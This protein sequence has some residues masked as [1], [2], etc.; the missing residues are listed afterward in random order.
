MGRRIAIA[1]VALIASCQHDHATAP[2]PVPAPAPVAKSDPWATKPIP[3]DPLPHPLLWSIEKDGHTTFAL[4]TIHMG[5]DPESR[6]PDS[7]WDKL[8]HAP[9]FAMETDVSDPSLATQMSERSDGGSLHKDLG[10][11]Y[12]RKL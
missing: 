10:D 5:V 3:K 2:A 7:V 8:D 12:W 6:L 9:T 4:G 1:L 11:A